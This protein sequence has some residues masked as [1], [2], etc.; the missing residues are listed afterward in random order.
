MTITER[1][2]AS[3]LAVTV[4]GAD[5]YRLRSVL[6]G[7]AAVASTDM[8]RGALCAV[9][10]TVAGNV[11]TATAT[12]SYAVLQASITLAEGLAVA[13]CEILVNA[14]QLT[15]A[16]K[17]IGKRTESVSLSQTGHVLTVLTADGSANA[18]LDYGQFA[19]SVQ[20][21]IDQAAGHGFPTS[22]DTVLRMNP[23]M[24]SSLLAAVATVL[25]TD[26]PASTLVAVGCDKAADG[27]EQ[28]RKPW[29]WS[30]DCENVSA[31]AVIMPLRS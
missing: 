23:A 16:V 6:L 9:R 21:I 3:V 13:D 11:L 15:K 8:T 12:D 22:A 1:E 30:A 14:K 20:S 27:T 7:V 26:L 17:L 4:T 29:L 25:P 10:L 31:R 5:C 24:L 18:D 2:T 28:A 19:G